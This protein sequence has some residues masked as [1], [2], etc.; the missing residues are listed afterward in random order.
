M[1]IEPKGKA[2]PGLENMRIGANA[3]PKCD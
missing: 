1:G 3:D 2:V